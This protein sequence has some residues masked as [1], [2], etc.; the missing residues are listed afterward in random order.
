MSPELLGVL[1]FFAE[2]VCGVAFGHTL[3]E[4]SIAKGWL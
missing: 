4:W 2:V 1:T 3:Y